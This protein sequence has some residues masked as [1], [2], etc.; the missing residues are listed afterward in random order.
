MMRSRERF[1]AAMAHRSPDRVPID[2]Q[3]KLPVREKLKDLYDV[4][5]EKELLDTLGCDFYYL[6]VRD[7]SQNETMLPIYHGPKLLFSDTERVCPFGIRFRRTVGQDKFGADEAVAGPLEKSTTVKEILEYPLPDPS[8]FDM[9]ALA[10]ECEEYSDK[11]IIGG[12]WTAIFGD[13]YRMHGF[14]NFLLNMSMNPDLIHCLIERMTDFYL[15]LNER[16]FTAIGRRMD[17]FFMGNDFGSQGGLLFSE[18]MWLD[19]FHD[20]YERIISHAK[21]KGYAVMVHSCGAIEPLLKHFISCGVDI[22]D[23]VQ[24]TASGMDQ[25]V[26]KERYGKQLVFHGAIDTQGVLPHGSQEDVIVHVK[27][28]VKTL[29]KEGGYLFA[30]C[31]S[32]QND[33]PIENVHAMYATARDSSWQK[34]L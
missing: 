7:I 27:E 19:F 24:T 15:E 3:A 13:S 8:W 29:G 2:Y 21:R 34:D 22:L 33:T 6:S 18:Q 28:T 20:P 10:A 23:P 12:F 9:D 11:V 25:A 4:T 32:L 17:I 26:L 16:L 30:S 14:E 1:L 31:N 5:T